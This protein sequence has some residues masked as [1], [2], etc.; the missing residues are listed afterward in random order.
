MRTIEWLRDVLLAGPLD[1]NDVK[2]RAESAGVTPKVLRRAREQLRVVIERSGNR[3]Q[4]R[5]TWRL[6]PTRP[7][8]LSLSAGSV[9]ERCHAPARAYISPMP[10]IGADAGATPIVPNALTRARAER[11]EVGTSGNATRNATP[12]ALLGQGAHRAMV[13]IATPAREST[14]AG[15]TRPA[16]DTPRA[17]WRVVLKFTELERR[18][19]EA[20]T[21]QFV[22]RGVPPETARAAATK[23]IV[24]RDRGGQAGGSCAEC[25]NF[26]GNNCQLVSKGF[27]EQVRDVM[28][29]FE[30]AYARR[31]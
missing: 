29:I 3:R 15:S 8:P 31:D 4:M 1:S 12:F 7:D 24:A 10:P 28:E 21:E 17:K 23:L 19:L 11:D 20:R 9:P 5:S 30:C 13:E 22:R 27:V 26:V 18:L 14:E 6:P 25:Q 16:S 2:A